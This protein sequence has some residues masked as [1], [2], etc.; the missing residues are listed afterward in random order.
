MSFANPS[1][2]WW[3]IVAVP[4][5]I[6]YLLK[7]RLRR[8]PVGTT[9]FWEHV[10][11]EKQPR[12]IWR[13]LRHLTSLLM[14]LL[15][16]ALFVFALADP[17]LNSTVRQQQRIVVVLDTSASMQAIDASGRLFL[18]VAREHVEELIAGLR[19]SDEMAL[20]VTG[21]RARV[22]CGLT[23]HPRMLQTALDS[24]VPTDAPGKMTEA[25][26]LGKRL[27]ADHPQ[28]QMVVVTDGLALPSE[29]REPRDN[30]SLVMVS[31]GTG[32]I[33][34]SEFQLRRS[35][36]D[37]VGYQIL[38]EVANFQDQAAQVTVDLTLNDSLLDV[39]PFTLQPGEIRREIID[40]TTT[41]GGILK[42][43]L[44][45]DETDDFESPA[46]HDA[47]A[48]DN[49]AFAVLPARETVPVTLVTDGN[50]FLQRAL[51]AS[52]L[53]DLTVT[54]ERPAVIAPDSVLILDRH[55]PSIIP[56]GRVLVV[57]PDASSD[58]WSVTGTV[59]QPLVGK[60]DDSSP[61]LQHVRLDNVLMPSAVQMMPTAAHNVLVTAVSNDP[62]YVRFPRRD[63]D[64]LV[65]NI[66]LSKGDL[67][68]R[69]AFPILLTNA[70][71]WFSGDEGTF[72]RSVATGESI[73]LPWQ[74]AGQTPANCELTSPSSRSQ[75]CAVH[76]NRVTIPPLEKAGIW[77]LSAT[78]K[79]VADSDRR[80]A[81]NVSNEAESDLRE[82]ARE[83][84]T[85]ASA[86]P[87]SGRPL[88]FYAVLCALA[89]LV[90][91]WFLFQRRW[92]M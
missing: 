31:E 30:L 1:A 8:V 87:D 25:M 62:L 68:L 41:S 38:L 64:A 63:G 74:S 66:D 92:I 81:C 91:E 12:A 46:V 15:L 90:A 22:V 53:V 37:P 71:T 23:S 18:D 6:F 28:K 16:V 21:N 86:L 17:V 10:F 20:V 49:W 26:A 88:W 58:L 69:T 47:L 67:P 59:E 72:A 55:V 11:E 57:R 84:T 45:F 9:M 40:N 80:L 44:T 36:L 42:A 3:A 7:L 2:L 73:T 65:L 60:Q 82:P 39:L 83:S 33:A 54:S 51:E 56:A 78:A 5:I 50:W 89:L 19:T 77:T 35:V 29:L 52:D 34:I 14:Q 85:T 4:V 61:L 76:N 27:L 75:T 32:N 79:P 24:V 43:V 48:A 13:Q 70:M